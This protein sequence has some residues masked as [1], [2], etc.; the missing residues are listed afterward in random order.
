M[1]IAQSSARPAVPLSLKMKS[2]RSGDFAVPKALADPNMITLIN[3]LLRPDTVSS[4]MLTYAGAGEALGIASNVCD[5][6]SA[7]HPASALPVVSSLL[8][9]GASIM[10]CAAAA[11]EE[12]QGGFWWNIAGVGLGVVNLVDGIGAFNAFPKIKAVVGVLNFGSKAYDLTQAKPGSM[13]GTLTS[14]TFY[15]GLTPTKS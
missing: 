13:G 4:S 1:R 2:V 14:L 9:V 6:V 7:D 10:G 11:K 15:S 8:G 12:D 3:P 5:L